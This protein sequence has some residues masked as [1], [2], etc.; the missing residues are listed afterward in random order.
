MAETEFTLDDVE[1]VEKEVLHKGF[2]TLHRYHLKHKLFA[3]GWT[4]VIQREM[5]EREPA[6]ALLPYDPILDRV[7]LLEQ[8]RLGAVPTSTKPW[9]IELVAGI[10]EEGETPEEV[11][12]RESQEEAGVKVTHLE[13][14][15]SYLP[16]PGGCTERLTLFVGCVDSSNAG[17]L[18]G[19]EHEHEDIRVYSVSREEAL[20]LLANGKID[21]AATII[22]LQW[23]ALNYQRVQQEWRSHIG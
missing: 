12:I 15:C 5:L 9:L 10:L 4:P 1:I 20:E 8:F 19:V 22:G 14:I 7:V 2:F 17:G 23:L 16:S 3:G 13:T 6:A 11:A 21:N 18:H